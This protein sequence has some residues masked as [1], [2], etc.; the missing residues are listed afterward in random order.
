MTRTGYE[1]LKAELDHLENVDKPRILEGIATA[2]AEGDL[3]E[4]AEYHGARESLGMLQARIN[5]M[6]DKLSRAVL[7]DPANVKRGEVSFGA[8]VKVRDLDCG[9]EEEFT[10]VGAGEEDYMTGKILVTSPMAQ[11]LLGRKIGDQTQIQVPMGTLRFEIVEIR[12]ESD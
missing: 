2:R 6:R 10:L 8:T 11:G 4:N 5:A 12:F 1:K 3:S 9:D 7:I